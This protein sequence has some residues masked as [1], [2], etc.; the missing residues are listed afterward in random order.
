MWLS[1]QFGNTGIEFTRI[2]AGNNNNNNI[3]FVADPFNQPHTV[4]GATGSAFQNEIDVLDPDYKYP[5]LMRGNLAY[6]RELPWGLVG[7]AEVVFTNDIQDI[8]YQNLNRVPCAQAQSGCPGGATT[9]N[10]DGRQILNRLNNNFSDVIFLT[11]S[12]EGHS[13]STMFEV[14]RPFRNRWFAQGSYIYGVS[15]S[16]MDGTSSQAASNWGN[17]LVPDDPSNPPLAR[18]SYD[19]GHRINF[20]GLY[21]IPI[22]VGHHHYGVG[23]LLRPVRTPV[24]ADVLRRHQRR[25]PHGIDLERS[26]VH[27]GIRDAR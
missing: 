3:P 11:N 5:S 6:D 8:E 2:G 9:L 17:V 20:S 22:V 15:K 19:P 21:E 27:P 10:L 13:Y 12:G 1:N 7:T 23:L 25:R 4:T 18:S 26:A 14:R 24:H 16:I